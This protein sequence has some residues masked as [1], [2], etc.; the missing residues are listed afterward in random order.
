[1][2]R[3]ESAF[4]RNQTVS[5]PYSGGAKRGIGVGSSAPPQDRE[6]WSEILQLL[7]QPR[8]EYNEDRA[9][10]VFSSGEIEGSVRRDGSVV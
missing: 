6:N 4:V 9:L 3:K 10:G 5:H 8:E 2:Y 7:E 1:M